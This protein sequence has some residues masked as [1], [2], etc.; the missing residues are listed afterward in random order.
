ML[1]WRNL[2][3][4]KT[5]SRTIPYL[6]T[7]SRTIPYLSTLPSAANQI[8]LIRH[9]SRQPIKIKYYLTRKPSAKVEDPSRLSARYS[10]SLIHRLFNP[11]PDVL[12]LLLLLLQLN[13]Q[14]SPADLKLLILVWR[15]DM[16]SHLSSVWWNSN[17]IH[18][19]PSTR[20]T[21]WRQP[22]I[23]IIQRKINKMTW[24][25]CT[26]SLFNTIHGRKHLESQGLLQESPA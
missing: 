3:Y 22:S 23:P 14:T 9:P 24:Q 25:I 4:R 2:P 26:I 7:S 11:A 20:T 17:S 12:S 6:N 16:F 13:L 15:V 18:Q 8:R 19:S 10:L 1:L 21:N 5:L